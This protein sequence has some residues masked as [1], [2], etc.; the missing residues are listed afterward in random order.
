MVA[1]SSWFNRTQAGLLPGSYRWQGRTENGI[2]ELNP[3]T[4]TSGADAIS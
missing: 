1:W 4:L 2:D 3:K